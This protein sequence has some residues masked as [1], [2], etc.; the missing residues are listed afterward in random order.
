MDSQH[1]PLAPERKRR[2]QLPGASA[3]SGSRRD[4]ALFSHSA[5]TQPGGEVGQLVVGEL[6]D[7]SVCLPVRLVALDGIGRS[8]AARP[9]ARSTAPHVKN[10][11]SG[12]HP[13]LR[14]RAAMVS[15]E[16]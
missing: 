12:G 16:R 5:S 14:I 2:T 8:P 11:G 9:S 6:D 3:D 7:I 13:A 1:L 15:S 10:N 4:I